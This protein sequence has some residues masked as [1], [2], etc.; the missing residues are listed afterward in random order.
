MDENSNALGPGL[1][2]D[3][4]FQIQNTL[5]HTLKKLQ[6]NSFKKILGVPHGK[7]QEW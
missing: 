3:K 4:N 6:I 1:K 2:R 7:P 5:Q